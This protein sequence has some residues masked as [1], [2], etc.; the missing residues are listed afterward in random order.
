[1]K[2]RLTEKT[3]MAR[4]ANKYVVYYM[5]SDGAD[6]IPLAVYE[7]HKDA[8]AYV[9]FLEKALERK[10][11]VYIKYQE[12]GSRKLIDLA[13]PRRKREEGN[14]YGDWQILAL[15]D[16]GLGEQLYWCRCKGCG[17]ISL[18]NICSI[19]GGRSRCCENCYIRGAKEHGGKAFGPYLIKLSSEQRKTVYD[20]YD[21]HCAYCGR[22]ISLSQ[23]EISAISRKQYSQKKDLNLILPSCRICNRGRKIKSIPQYKLEIRTSHEILMRYQSIY[24]LA[25]R[26]NK[27]QWNGDD[28]NFYFEQEEGRN[29]QIS[30]CSQ[31]EKSDI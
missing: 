9:R 12:E 19:R 15:A 25:L 14:T 5:D 3:A 13:H 27:V 23:M 8:K 31:R 28:F 26:F 20:R 7:E 29:E 16:K 1:M 11:K 18:R 24:C 22:E 2:K 10:L 30:A 6:Q 17:E 21:G 4:T